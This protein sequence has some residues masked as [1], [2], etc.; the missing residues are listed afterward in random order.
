MRHSEG[1]AAGAAGAAVG[2]R[3]IRERL[4]ERSAATE[5]VLAA[6]EGGS[7][8]F[9]HADE[10]SD[11][12]LVLVVAPERVESAFALVESALAELSEISDRLRLPEPAW[13]GHSQAFYRLAAASP[14]HVVDLLVIRE[15]AKGLFLEPERHG[16]ARW[17]FDRIGVERPPPLDPGTIAEE[18]RGRVEAIRARHRVLGNLPGKELR[19]GRPIDALAFYQSLSL[20]HLVELLRIRHDPFRATFGLR[21]LGH[22][23]PAEVRGRLEPLLF[24]GSPEELAER[25]P[26]A[27]A[28]IEELLGEG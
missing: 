16:R 23:L 25:L 27:D 3:E 20:R 1:G 24:V 4:A 17:L 21:Y 11:I 14:D 15:G 18:N 2:R 19:R 7:A 26:R 6:W 22:D 5:W 8:A 13:H 10:L 12:D 28:W 9:D